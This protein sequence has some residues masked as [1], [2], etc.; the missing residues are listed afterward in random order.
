MFFYIFFLLLAVVF[1]FNLFSGGGSARILRKQFYGNYY[2]EDAVTDRNDKPNSKEA[3]EK[4]INAGLGIKTTVHSSKDKRAFVSTYDDLSREYGIDKK[5]SESDSEE[6]ESLGIMPVAQL[7]EIIDGRVPVVIQLTPGENN[8]ALCR[9]V[10]DAINA[11]PHTNIG[12]TSFHT[13]M[14]SWF[15]Q[16]EKKIFRGLTSA[17]AK[18]FVALPAMERFLTGNL[19]YNSI[20][21]PQ[22]VLYRNKPMSILVKFAFAIGLIR[23]IWTIT[24]K[25]E[26]EKLEA[27]K[28]MIVIRGFMPERPHYNDLPE[29][30]ITQMEKDADKKY[31]EKQA[32]KAA[33]A[34][35]RAE[36]EKANHKTDK[37]FLEMAEDF[38]GEVEE[39]I[40]TAEDIVESVVEDIKEKAEEVIEKIT[41]E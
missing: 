31:E 13:G 40:E 39:Y 16:K 35:R 24:D 34:Q 10:A 21:R 4:C 36:R 32:R 20:S 27:K 26:G 38:S 41:E 19:V 14:I 30:E 5:I 6:L 33:R 2:A 17:P 28:D 3:I 22:F 11:C 29:R 8:E 9:Y 25:A 37:A 1:I 15:K 12:V 18:D 23:G 7:I